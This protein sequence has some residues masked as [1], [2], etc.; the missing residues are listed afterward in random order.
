MEKHAL[1]VEFMRNI[2]KK[3]YFLNIGRR[4]KRHMSKA[5]FPGEK[6]IPGGLS[7][8][9]IEPQEI[10]SAQKSPTYC[11]SPDPADIFSHPYRSQSQ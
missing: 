11:F 1:S 3:A 2:G 9:K 4:K 6:R 7:E 5:H 10:L 8:S